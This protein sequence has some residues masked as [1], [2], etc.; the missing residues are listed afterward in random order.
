ME[1]NMWQL[2][3]AVMTHLKLWA[4]YVNL[5]H[6]LDLYSFFHVVLAHIDLIYVPPGRYR[7][8]MSL[9]K[10]DVTMNPDSEEEERG[11]FKGQFLYES[12]SHIHTQY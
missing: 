1:P 12:L 9:D 5:T 7:L 6:K 8:A 10:E 11:K 4:S 3:L 2:P